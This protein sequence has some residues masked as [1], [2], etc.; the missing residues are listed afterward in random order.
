MVNYYIVY[1][2]KIKILNLIN[3][4]SQK[5][6]LI[7]NLKPENISLGIEKLNSNYLIE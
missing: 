3:Q 6:M 7:E 4:F 2:R 1:Q 5:F